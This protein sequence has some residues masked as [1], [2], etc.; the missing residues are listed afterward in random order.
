MKFPKEFFDMVKSGMKTCTGRLGKRDLNAG[1]EIVFE[2]ENESIRVVVLEITFY[3]SFESLL[4]SHLKD[5]LPGYDFYGG[6]AVYNGIYGDKM[7]EMKRKGETI[8]IT[9][10]RFKLIS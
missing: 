8:I 7:E 6:L 1:D 9:G 2:C 3:T 5:V 10:I 4:E